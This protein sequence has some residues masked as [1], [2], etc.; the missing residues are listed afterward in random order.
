MYATS[1]S[2]VPETTHLPNNFRRA[3]AGKELGVNRITWVHP[4]SLPAHIH[5]DAEKAIIVL[6]GAISFTVNA[7]ELTLGEG[8]VAIVPRNAVHSGHSIEG[9]AVF[10]EIFAPMRIENL[11][12]FLG[13]TSITIVEA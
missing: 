8:D 12:A 10:I 11:A 6:Q 3:V 1:W 13:D 2:Q 7:E 9:K 4:T 5:E